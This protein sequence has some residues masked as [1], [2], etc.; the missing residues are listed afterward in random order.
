MTAQTN[1]V[2]PAILRL[3]MHDAVVQGC[4]ASIL[5]TSSINNQAERDYPD[6]QSIRQEA[7]DAI[8]NAK[9]AVE[10][11]CPGVVSCADILALAARDAVVLSG[12]PTWDVP[13][14]RLDS[15]VSSA[16]NVARHLPLANM[17]VQQLTTI[18]APLDLSMLDVIVLSGEKRLKRQSQRKRVKDRREED[19]EEM[20]EVFNLLQ[21]FNYRVA[22]A[23]GTLV[24]TFHIK[25]M[26]VHQRIRI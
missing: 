16:S 17:D 24:L 9:A 12:G 10:A 3:V 21:E 23:D 7:F 13:L 20:E 19:E 4:D 2:P 5:I 18:F 11:I 1:V 15:L 8:E 14:G 25:R 6:N 22:I 26:W